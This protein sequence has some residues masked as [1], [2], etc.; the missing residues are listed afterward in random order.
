MALWIVAA[1]IVFLSFVETVGDS[2][3]K[4]SGGQPD[5]YVST[6]WLV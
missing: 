6:P 1:G 2:F 3:I 5:K 4:N